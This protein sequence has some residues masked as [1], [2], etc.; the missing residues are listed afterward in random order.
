MLEKLHQLILPKQ[1]ITVSNSSIATCCVGVRT[2]ATSSFMAEALEQNELI[3]IEVFIPEVLVQ[4][5][6]DIYF[7]ADIEPISIVVLGQ[8]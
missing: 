2:T 5:N 6:Y 3:L 4:Y 7:F 1:R 8:P